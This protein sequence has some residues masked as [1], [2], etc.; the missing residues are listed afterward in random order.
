MQPYFFPNLAHF[1][2]IAATD[3]WV[4]FDV[5]QYT[6]KSWISRNRILH[7]NEG[8]H[9]ISVPV[10]KSSLSLKISEVRL[11]DTAAFHNSVRGKLSHYRKTAPHYDAVCGLVD[12]CFSD[13]PDDRLV[14]LNLATLRAV[15]R[16]LEIPFKPT[17]CSGLGL[18]FPGQMGPGDWAPFI[19]N[20]LGAQ[21]YI[22]PFGGRELFDSKHFAQLG[23]ELCFARFG[24]F[25]YATPG[26]EYI[27]GLSILDV[28]MWNDPMTVRKA[29]LDLNQVIR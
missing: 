11:S 10:Q 3:A 7:P 21:S 14:T 27:P 8:W 26:Y 28:L 19:A 23:I 9:Y 1:A 18:E 13:L 22:N 6:K 16:Y 17:I 25:E 20:A 12:R 5:T 24:E 29:A 4:V 2:L 15:C